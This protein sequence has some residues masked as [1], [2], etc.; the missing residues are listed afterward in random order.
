METS[1]LMAADTTLADL[2]EIHLFLR[3]LLHRID[4]FELTP[5]VAAHELFTPQF[6]H[7]SSS[8]DSFDQM[9]TAAGVVIVQWIDELDTNDQWKRFIVDRTRFES[10]DDMREEAVRAWI[11]KE[12]GL[13][14]SDPGMHD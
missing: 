13:T 11:A 6:M 7:D 10:W 5:D 8:F 2:D 14:H 4:A 1:A 3:D 12:L 9:V